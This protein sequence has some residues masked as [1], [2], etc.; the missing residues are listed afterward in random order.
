MLYRVIYEIRLDPHLRFLTDT[1]REKLL[2]LQSLLNRSEAL[3]L[4]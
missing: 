2:V 4:N 3:K 1:S